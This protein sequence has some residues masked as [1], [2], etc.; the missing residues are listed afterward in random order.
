MLVEA[1]DA[2]RSGRPVSNTAAR[3]LG[4][5]LSQWLERGGAFGQCAKVS[6]RGDHNTVSRI[7]ARLNVDA[8]ERD[9]DRVAGGVPFSLRVRSSSDEDGGG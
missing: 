1:A 5:A 9:R 7:V 6:R 8:V 3:L 2:L 4:A